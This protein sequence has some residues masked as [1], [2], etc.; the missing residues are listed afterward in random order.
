MTSNTEENGT[1]TLSRLSTSGNSRSMRT[2]VTTHV[3]YT[4]T[5]KDM[6]LILFTTS[7]CSF[8]TYMVWDCEGKQIHTS[9]H[10]STM[11]SLP[12]V[13][14]FSF[15][16]GKCPKPVRNR[17]V[18]TLRS[19]LPIGKDYIIMNYSVK[20]VVSIHTQTHT[21]KM[22]C[23]GFAHSP[24]HNSV[25]HGCSKVHGE[26]ILK[27]VHTGWAHTHTSFYPV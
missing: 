8:V 23:W 20:H 26:I 3:C 21:K 5:S 27:W 4:P 12:D 19:W 22:L 1:Q 17:D 2:L 16:T 11:L 10:W 13:S 24:L 14:C 18:I 25:H 9:A 7:V 6:L 15:W